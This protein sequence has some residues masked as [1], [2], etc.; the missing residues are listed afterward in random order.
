MYRHKTQSV[1]LEHHLLT[2]LETKWLL[3]RRQSKSSTN[4][5]SRTTTPQVYRRHSV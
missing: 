5:F 4:Y 1:F 3:Y 2:A